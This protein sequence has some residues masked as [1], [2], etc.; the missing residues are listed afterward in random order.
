MLQP[1][2]PLRTAEDIDV[3]VEQFRSS[4]ARTLVSVSEPDSHPAWTW[5]VDDDGLLDELGSTKPDATRRQDL[6]EVVAP[7]GAIFLGLPE[8]LREE[9]TF[10]TENTATYQ[11]PKLRSIDIDTPDDLSIA[12]AILESNGGVMLSASSRSR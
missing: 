5:G 4:D 12:E 2:S 1:T 3:A 10:Y 8:T 11:M 9:R 7:N 6:P